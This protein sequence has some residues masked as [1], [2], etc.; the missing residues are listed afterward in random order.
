MS[1]FQNIAPQQRFYYL[2]GG[3]A[4]L[5]IISYQFS[6]SKTL[7]YYG[8][9]S[10]NQQ[11]LTAAASAPQ[12]IQHYQKLLAGLAGNGQEGDY[13]RAHLFEVV[14]TFCRKNNLKLSQFPP[15]EERAQNDYQILT[16]QIEVE[17]NYVDMVKLGYELEFVKKLGHIASASFKQERDIRTR[18]RFLKGVFYLQ[19]LTQK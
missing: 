5:L 3:F 15:E 1:I 13:D 7:E 2:L 14:N 17:G 18:R 11:S 16:N 9:Y 19:H 10:K 12:Q 6:I 4:F 8:K